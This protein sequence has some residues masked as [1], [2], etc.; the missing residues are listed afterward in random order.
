[1]FIVEKCSNYVQHTCWT[2]K[3]ETLSKWRQLTCDQA[4]YYTCLHKEI[5]LKKICFF[6]ITFWIF[7]MK[8]RLN[9]KAHFFSVFMSESFVCCKFNYVTSI[10]QTNGWSLKSSSAEI[11]KI[12]K[13]LLYGLELESTIYDLKLWWQYNEVLSVNEL[14]QDG[15]PFQRF[16]I[17]YNAHHKGLIWQ[18]IPL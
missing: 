6:C 15:T 17:C 4:L 14:C 7:V 12:M 1:M 16:K 5:M 10:V 13:P 11:W 18:A 9:D 2:W 3:L 8:Q